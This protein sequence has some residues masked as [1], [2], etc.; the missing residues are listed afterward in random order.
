M[1]D[2]ELSYGPPSASAV[3]ICVDMQ[4]IFAERTEWTMPWRLRVLPNVVEITA[5]HPQHTIFTRFIPARKVGKGSGMSRRYYERWSSMTID[6][7]GPDLI[8]LLPELTRF[9]PPA[10]TYNKYVYSPGPEATYTPCC[11]VRLSI[12]LSSPAA[13]RTSAFWPR[14]WAPSIGASASFS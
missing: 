4:R 5:A 10:R 2:G 1:K 13:R 12:P 7:L 11:G 8:D 9:V 6:E 14:C 3:H